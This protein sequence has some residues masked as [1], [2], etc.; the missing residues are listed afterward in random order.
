MV[1]LTTWLGSAQ[2]RTKVLGEMGR[3]AP[4][5]AALPRTAQMLRQ[6]LRDLDGF[7]AIAKPLSPAAGIIGPSSIRG[8]V[9]L[10]AI[11]D[12]Q[13]ALTSFRKTLIGLKLAPPVAPP[14]PRRPNISVRRTPATDC[15]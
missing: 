15:D 11:A 9:L 5:P 3:Q 7:V 6:V 1:A 2:A 10:R 14:P 8:R 4:Q 12:L 13:R